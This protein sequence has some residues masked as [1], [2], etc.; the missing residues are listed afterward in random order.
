MAPTSGLDIV[1]FGV[2]HEGRPGGRF[3]RLVMPFQQV[4]ELGFVAGTRFPHRG[5]LKAVFAHDARGMVAK[6][7]VKR[8]LVGL[9]NLIDAK[10]MDHDRRCCLDP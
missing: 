10:L 3:C 9:E 6:A 5:D 8:G 4:D 1:P 2:A 7:R